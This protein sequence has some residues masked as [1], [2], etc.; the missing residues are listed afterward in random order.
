MESVWHRTYIAAWLPQGHYDSPNHVDFKRG[1]NVLVNG[2]STSLGT[3]TYYF[4]VTDEVFDGVEVRIYQP[5]GGAVPNA[6]V[7]YN[8]GGGWVHGDVGEIYTGFIPLGFLLA[9]TMMEAAIIAQ[10][11]ETSFQCSCILVLQR[12]SLTL[13]NVFKKLSHGSNVL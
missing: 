6:A 1:E 5:L 2:R 9:F 12:E 7:V 4:Q 10:M 8:H 13:D 3:K 11:Y